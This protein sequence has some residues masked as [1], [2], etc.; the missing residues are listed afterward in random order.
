MLSVM[1]IALFSHKFVLSSLQGID[2]KDCKFNIVSPGADPDVYFAYTEED[3]RKPLK[4]SLGKAG[5]PTMVVV[6]VGRGPIPG[7]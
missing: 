3:K 4:V 1:M 5:N 2:V 6:A 7:S